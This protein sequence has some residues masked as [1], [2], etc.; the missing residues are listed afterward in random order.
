[1]YTRHWSAMNVGLSLGAIWSWAWMT[2]SA[3]RSREVMAPPPNPASVR[4]NT[5]H[6]TRLTAL[7]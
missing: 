2:Y 6:F 3:G 5:S 7:Q 4:S 1:M